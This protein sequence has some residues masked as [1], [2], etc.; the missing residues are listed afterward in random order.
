MSSFAKKVT[1]F[2]AGILAMTVISA[3]ST[4]FP[5]GVIYTGVS[6]PA[7]LGNGELA[8]R[9]SASSS[10]TSILNIIAVGNASLNA[11]ASEG[12]ITKISWATYKALNILT[13][14]GKY[15][16]TVYGE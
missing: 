11:A 14:Y 7:A 5:Q 6:L 12:A 2:M 16:V 3:C 4:T 10:A 9:K 15:T 13:I 1:V 8:Y